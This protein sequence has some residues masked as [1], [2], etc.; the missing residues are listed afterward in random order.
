MNNTTIQRVIFGL[1]LSVFLASCGGGE[2]N[3]TATP[4]PQDTPQPTLAPPA[5]G[6]P[7]APITA[8]NAPQLAYL[9]RLDNTASSASSVFAHA[10]SLDGTRL[11]GLNNDLIIM[12]NLVTGNTVFTAGRRFDVR[13]FFSPNKDEFYTV[14]SDGFIAIYDTERG[15]T[16]NTL[17]LAVTLDNAMAH[18]DENGWLAVGGTGGD[19]QVW[20]VSE[21]LSKA[22]FKAHETTVTAIAF[23]ADGTQLATAGGDG[24]VRVW[25]WQTRAQLNEFNLNEAG[26]IALAFSPDGTQITAGTSA[27][28]ETYTLTEN[29]ALYALAVGVGGTRD[30]MRYSPN[31]EYLLSGGG[32]ADLTVMN[33]QTGVVVAQIVEVKGE[34]IGAT[35][36]T[37]GNLMITSAF[38]VGV[39]LWDIS[40]ATES[41]IPSAK[42]AIGTNRI[43]GVAWTRDGFLM[44]FFDANGSVYLWGIP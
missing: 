12:W 37:D 1:L 4:R 40:Q 19:V 34:R 42:L 24:F 2:A 41:T 33:A 32:E 35:F 21:R 44:A 8:Q 31:G 43:T 14:T 27:Y 25:D 23:N 18:D 29:R 22:T 30:I 20:D 11:V 15:S 26:V 5:Y 16:L 39:S 6:E 7:S 3:P 9:G 17:T 10:F 36:G 13:V 28:V 38:D